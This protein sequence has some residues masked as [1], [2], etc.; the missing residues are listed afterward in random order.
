MPAIAIAIYILPRTIRIQI[1]DTGDIV[2]AVKIFVAYRTL[3]RLV[4]KWIRQI[5]II[6]DIPAVIRFRTA[7]SII[8]IDQAASVALRQLG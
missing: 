5:S 1:V 3:I 8:I 2:I 4:I 6:V 7:I